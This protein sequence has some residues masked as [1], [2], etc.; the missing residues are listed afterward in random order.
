MKKLFTILFFWACSIYSYGQFPLQQS[1]GSSTT[2]VYSK[3]GLGSDSGF[4]YRTNFQDTVTANIS[5]IKNIPGITIRTGNVLWMRNQAATAW[6]R[7]GVG[8]SLVANGIAMSGDTTIL[9]D[10]MNR[11]TYIQVL[12]HLKNGSRY[13]ALI[14]GNL[15]E[16]QS[17]NGILPKYPYLLTY[18]PATL[19]LQRVYSEANGD[20]DS[21]F[22][23]GALSTITRI[24]RDSNST[25]FKAGA[26]NELLAGQGG[27]FVY[28]YFPPRDSMVLKVGRDGQS[29]NVIFGQLD[30]GDS[31]GYNMNIVP[32]TSLP[33]FP[34]SAARTSIDLMRVIDNT[35][36]KKIVGAGI[37]GF[38]TMYKSYQTA[39]N[40]A[41]YEAGNYWENMFGLRVYGD[42]Y[43]LISG[44]TKAKTLLVA[45]VK[46]GYGLYVDPQYRYTNTVD[47]GYSFYAAGD[48]DILVNKGFAY[49]GPSTTPTRQNN[50]QGLRYRTYVTGKG[51][52]TD[53]LHANIAAA[54]SLAV[55]M[56]K[57]IFDEG[58]M[59]I[60]SQD[61]AYT[62][63]YGAYMPTSRDS[64]GAYIR[65]EGYSSGVYDNN[66]TGFFVQIETGANHA[67]MTRWWR[68]GNMVVNHAVGMNQ[69]RLYKKFMVNGSSLFTDTVTIKNIATA[70]VDTSGIKI[71]GINSNGDVFKTAWAFAGGGGG[72]SWNSITNPTG[73]QTLSWD[74]AELNAWTNGS[75]TET[76]HTIDNNSLTTGTSFKWNSSSLTTGNLLSLNTTSTALAAGNKALEI[77][78]SGANATNGVTATGLDVATT[79]T[80]ATSGTNIGASFSASGATT[81]NIAVNIPTGS[82][83]VASSYTG[84]Q[85]ALSVFNVIL[86][87]GNADTRT[88]IVSNNSA[89]ATLL[90]SNSSTPAGTGFYLGALSNDLVGVNISGTQAFR[91][92]SAGSLIIGTTTVAAGRLTLPAGTTAAVSAPIKFTSGTNMTTPEAGA[93]EFD[94]TNYFGTASTTRYTFAKTLTNT[95]TLDFPDTSPNTSSDL[96]ITVTGLSG[97]E[98]VSVGVPNASTAA[99]SSYSAW[100][101]SANTVTVRFLNSQ[102]AGNINPASGTFRVSAIV[103]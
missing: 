25:I 94:G 41:T 35:R 33:L 48:T 53:S 100:V 10:S 98:S 87:A 50:T 39:I 83:R 66:G 7:I 22:Y 14:L 78:V 61:S 2:Q 63:L 31:W 59:T 15:P 47:N 81:D 45:T 4:I 38:T 95:A 89:G 96:T 46:N 55:E 74:D 37:S 86:G 67:N 88:I 18:N 58:V 70:P 65:S 52:Y 12:S 68:N 28:Q 44:A 60:S 32:E 5:F 26:R 17:L 101:S 75:N 40:M 36:R 23:G 6:L 103:Y 11:L 20:I 16:A 97:G 3:G 8:P 71:L 24:S 57:S 51:W 72:A 90:L 85:A 1:L 43:P 21:V 56:P 9:G 77:R 19:G 84:V 79:N 76:F 62:A 30:I 42:G 29:G 27:E 54:L 34:I 82:L 49:F 64:R 73:T 99:N 80:N 13:N 91:A 102:A 69:Y 92:T 93:M